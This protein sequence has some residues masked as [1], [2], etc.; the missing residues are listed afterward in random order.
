MEIEET[1]EVIVVAHSCLAFALRTP[2]PPQ[3]EATDPGIRFCHAKKASL[4]SLTVSE[5]SVARSLNSA[6]PWVRS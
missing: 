5:N 2:L 1:F 4:S 3:G 6:G